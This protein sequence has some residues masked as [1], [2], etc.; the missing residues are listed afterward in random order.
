M[1][2]SFPLVAS[3]L[4]S[5][6]S[7]NRISNVFLITAYNEFLNVTNN[8]QNQGIA[9]SPNVCF[10]KSFSLINSCQGDGVSYER[11]YLVYS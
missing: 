4:G 10:L 3:A 9:D 11:P 2:L 7:C 8:L 5:L 1:V 6:R